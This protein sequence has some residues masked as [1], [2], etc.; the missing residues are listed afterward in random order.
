[1]D[2]LKGQLPR[3]FLVGHREDAVDDG[4]SAGDPVS[5][6]LLTGQ[7]QLADHPTGIGPQHLISSPYDGRLLAQRASASM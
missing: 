7:E 5:Q 4:V 2:G 6:Y 1:M 3:H